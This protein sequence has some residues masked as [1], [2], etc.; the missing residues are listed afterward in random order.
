MVEPAC[1]PLPWATL[2]VLLLYRLVLGR[3]TSRY[4]PPQRFTSHYPAASSGPSPS[5]AGSLNFRRW[6][7]TAVPVE[8]AVVEPLDPF[9]GGEFHVID[10]AP[11]AALF[12]QLGLVET[13][14]R[15]G[16]RVVVARSDRADTR[17]ANPCRGPRSSSTLARTG[18]CCDDCLNLSCDPLSVWW[19]TSF[20]FHPSRSRVKMA[21]SIASRT[22]VVVI[23]V[24]VR[25]PRI[26][27][28]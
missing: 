18:L 15:L 14:D 10:S 23:D 19:T 8:A 28:A 26:L 2:R 24:D 6:D 5:R 22:N 13:V 1:C 11:R 3:G 9:G 16:E 4:S 12:D 27:C 17:L 7:V 25:Q 21:C 20:T